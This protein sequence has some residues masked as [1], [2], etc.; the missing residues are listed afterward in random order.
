MFFLKR[1]M[2]DKILK[3]RHKGYTYNQIRGELN[4]SK[5]TI[6]YHLGKNQKEKAKQRN[7]RCRSGARDIVY[8]KL[9]LFF[10]RSKSKI[11]KYKKRTREYDLAYKKIANHPYC[12]ITGRKIDLSDP[13]SYCLD[14]IVPYSLSGD[15][16]LNNL[17]LA[18]RDANQSKSD[19]T[20]NRFIDLC[21]EVLTN[22]GYVVKNQ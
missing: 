4:C 20:L 8:R 13:K 12:Y 14:H 6:S 11:I 10:T 1:A 15:N 5:G 2:G 19:L 17:G 9:D 7:I 22:N 16:S 18:C 21:K 3:L